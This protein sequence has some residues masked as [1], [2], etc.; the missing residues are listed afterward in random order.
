[1]FNF[2]LHIHS[3]LSPCGDL[4]SSPRE[5][6][7]RARAAGLHGLMLSDHNSARNTAAME[8][9]CRRE[10]LKV[11]CGMELTTAEEVHCLAVFDTREQAEA[12]SEF[13]CERLPAMVNDPDIFGTQVVVDADESV[14]EMETMLLAAPSGITIPEAARRIHAMG[15][16]FIA[17]HI[18]REYFSVTSQLGGIFGDEGF[19]AVE[20]SRHADLRRWRHRCKGLPV[21][22][23]SDAHYC[24]D[25][26]AIYNCA[27]L[28]EFSVAAL[29]EALQ[30]GRVRH[31]RRGRGT[32][33]S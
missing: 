17:C 12:L 14:I 19:D 8:E 1:M 15:G 25:I 30:S 20:V 24:E 33:G 4:D 6:G 2:D 3:C 32:A 26:G 16:L 27:E 28:A 9:I 18:D 31:R 22:R 23:N 11:L 21:L 13:V 5:I 29:K 10:G 7:R